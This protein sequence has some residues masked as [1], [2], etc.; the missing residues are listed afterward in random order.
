MLQELG[1]TKGRVLRY[2]LLPGIIPRLRDITGSGFGR[3]AYLIALVYSTVRILPAN[4]PYLRPDSIGRYGIRHVIAEAANHVVPSRHNIDQVIV[5]FAVLAGIIILMLQFVLLFLAVLIV[6]AQAAMPTSPSGFF[7][8]QNPEEDIAFRLL[9]LVFG[10]E[11]FFSSKEEVGTPFHTALHSLFEFY[12]FGLLIVGAFI[13]IYLAITVIAETAQSGTPFGQRFNHVWAPIRL[14]V[15]F[16]LLIPISSGLNSGQLISLG[17]A[18]VG[19]SL[20]TNGWLLFNETMAEETYLGAKEGLVALPELPELQHIP[21]FIM[22]ARTCMWAEG[23]RSTKL[24][25]GKVV[26]RDIQAYIVFAKGAEGRMNFE[27]AA[28]QD[29]LEKIAGG[30]EAAPGNVHIRFGEKDDEK[31]KDYLG[32]VSPYCGDMVVYVDD[33]SEPGSAVIQEGYFNLIKELWNSSGDTS[34]TNSG[35]ALGT[36]IDEFAR[37]FTLR[38]MTVEPRYPDARI[39]GP[40]FKENVVDLIEKDFT[41]YT[42]IG[43]GGIDLGKE[44]IFQKAV[45]AQI[46]KGDWSVD[47]KMKDYGW[48]GAGIWYNKVAEKNGALMTAARAVPSV[49]LYP[50]V[51]RQVAK[52]KRKQDN[53]S[54]EEDKFSPD[55]SSG[56]HITFD[57]EGQE[58]ISR[59]LFRVYQYWEKDGR[60]NDAESNGMTGNIIIDTIN[61]FLGTK[62]LFDMCK[63]TNVHPL[64]QLSGVG[65]SMIDSAI[66]GLAFSVGIG[67]TGGLG[68]LLSQHLGSAG[69]AASGFFGTMAA[70][71]LMVGFILFYVLPFLPFIYFFF[72]VGGWVKGIFEA[73]VGVPLWALAHLRIDGEGLP[74][75]AAY[76]GYILIFE[77]FL[78]PIL[79]VFGLLAGITIFAAMVRV[80]NEIFYLVLANLTGQELG[81]ASSTQCFKGPG[82]QEELMRGP[83]DEF[84]F[85]IIYTIIVYIIGM[86]CFKLIDLIPN[87][88]LRW[89]DHEVPTFNDQAGQPAEG[90]IKYVAI[91]GGTLGGQ[92][93]EGFGDV[94]GAFRE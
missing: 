89:I 51:M 24:V 6:P 12:S 30:T 59:V 75:D 68:T 83:V 90:L 69:F 92:L 73:M 28:F 31:Y 18:K 94:I 22:L 1:I 55:L 36:L 80:L 56:Q 71:G 8:T 88:I 43:P 27:G 14:I 37:N 5:F 9:D 23:R 91:G 34:N 25:D 13:I 62:G 42:D 16:A 17:A 57:E 72:A 26:Q 3:I 41:G 53:A 39:P 10:I 2:T 65:K 20:A 87:Q 48:G 38:Y 61:V 54:K 77:I 35:N 45:E 4:H 76:S 49:A 11:G 82:E 15:F 52:S 86:S 64:A 81:G 78:R 60:R 84:F 32:S 58:E 67:A 93:Q 44:G 7:I 79:I 47:K 33:I 46:E 21:A 66:S 74:G 85:T 29:V 40:A 63:N 50:D 19:S 70:I